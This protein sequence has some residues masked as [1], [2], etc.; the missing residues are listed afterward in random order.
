MALY[1]EGYSLAV[2]GGGQSAKAL[3]MTVAE[4][5]LHRADRAVPSRIAIFERFAE[6]GPGFAWSPTFMLDEHLTSQPAG[7]SRTAYGRMQ[8]V[9]F[10]K[11][12]V[13][14]ARLGVRVDLFP[15]TEVRQVIREADCWRL[16]TASGAW[17]AE[18]TVLATG[19]W[20]DE[21]PELAHVRYL[22]P[23]P[24]AHLGEAVSAALRNG[25]EIAV[26]GSYHTAIDV[27]LTTALSAGVFESSCD[28]EVSY[29]ARKP[30]RITLMSRRGALP[31]VWPKRIR[32]YKLRCLTAE[33]IAARSCRNGTRRALALA[34]LV[35]LLG[36]EVCGV[37]WRANDDPLKWLTEHCRRLSSIDS[38]SLLQ[39]AL[40]GAA[41]TGYSAWL[42]VLT[43][44]LPV[45]SESY[46]YLGARDDC[47]FRRDFQ[48]FFFNLAMPMARETAKRVLAL[49]RVGCLRVRA[50][51]AGDLHAPS[52]DLLINGR[53]SGGMI[54]RHPSSLMRSLL[55]AGSIQPG[56][57][58]DEM[59]GVAGY[60]KVAGV[61]IDPLTCEVIPSG[62][63]EPCAAASTRLY[64]MGPNVIG[65][66]LDAQSSGQLLRDADRILRHLMQQT[67]SNTAR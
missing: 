48:T 61:H 62:F 11:L 56:L 30:F 65:T 54:E 46:P 43:A 36:E 44:A 47:R 31:W 28:G 27:A 19:H 20:T 2:V 35:G 34:D 45:I 3:L 15:R 38:L 22:H 4:R 25:L 60:S 12:V 24:A 6:L 58:P 10:E 63:A 5:A 41:P 21:P 23:W 57:R 52:F 50:I 55:R 42:R 26:I 14:L 64:A 32:P 53:S 13:E 33:R 18:A 29:R 7:S 40:H 59:Q 16:V 9:V 67:K 39:Q 37:R 49:A 8:P 1:D 17:R 66:F 51:D